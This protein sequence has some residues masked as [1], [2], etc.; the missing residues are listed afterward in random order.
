MASGGVASPADPIDY[1][2]YSMD[3][4]VASVDEATRANKYVMA[5]AYMPAAIRRAVEAGVRSI[6]HGNF[7]D[8]ECAAMM[9][10][11][12]TFLVPT[13]IVY[14]RILSHGK[15]V[16]ASELHLQKAR[17][18][19]E[20]GTRSL[21]IAQR[22]GVKMAY[23]SD[24]FKAPKEFQSE[25][26]LVRAEVLPKADILRSATTTAAEL[27]GLERETGRIAPGYRADL[28]V[29]EGNPLEDFACLQDQ[30]R[31]LAIILKNGRRVKDVLTPLGPEPVEQPKSLGD[32]YLAWRRT[33]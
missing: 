30:G 28:L 27:L 33:R 12:G 21:E 26:F 18:V 9:V 14:R 19:S 25:E 8:E 32:N 5:H 16:G 22:A 6:E 17:Q 2:Q 10:A 7:L 24:L 13:L 29:V 11:R 3:E 20:L 1:V 4:L 31:H 23:G 15:Q